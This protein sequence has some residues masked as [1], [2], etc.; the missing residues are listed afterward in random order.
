MACAVGHVC[1]PGLRRTAAWGTVLCAAI[2]LGPS[3]GSPQRLGSGHGRQPI[4]ERFEQV[5][6]NL[7]TVVRVWNSEREDGVVL[8]RVVRVPGRLAPEHRPAVLAVFAGEE[9][10]ALGV[11]LLRRVAMLARTDRRVERLLEG[12]TL[13]LAAV[14]G[15]EWGADQ[16]QF[17]RLLARQG[18]PTHLLADYRV[19]WSASPGGAI[20]AAPP[21]EWRR[22]VEPGRAARH[23]EVARSLARSLSDHGPS[24]VAVEERALSAVLRR[25][26]AWYRRL[27]SWPSPPAAGES[28]T[29]RATREAGVMA[30]RVE[31]RHAVTNEADAEALTRQHLEGLLRLL[32]IVTHDPFATADSTLND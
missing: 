15:P 17:E 29:M 26:V 21:P 10:A 23:L 7:P 12:K 9:S 19:A 31:V 3:C 32:E 2:L 22:D 25:H 14:L 1:H 8:A 20:G 28:A 16:R 18:F 6:F 4:G 5:Q 30:L 27:W 24:Y 11:A 13:L